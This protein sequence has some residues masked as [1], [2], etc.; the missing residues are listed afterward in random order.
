MKTLIMLIMLLVAAGCNEEQV[1]VKA[2][3]NPNDPIY[4]FINPAPE[5]WTG[6]FGDNERTRLL[7]SISEL[8]VVVAAQGLRILSLE[9]PNRV[10]DE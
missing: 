5:D 3:Y 7:H 10:K 9:D 6:Q 8:R 1:T 4:K 2:G